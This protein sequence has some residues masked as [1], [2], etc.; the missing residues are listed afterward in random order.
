MAETET[1]YQIKKAANSVKV[2][3]IALFSFF[4]SLSVNE[5]YSSSGGWQNYSSLALVDLSF[6]YI[7]GVV[8]IELVKKRWVSCLLFMSVCASLIVT[9][10]MFLYQYY[11]LNFI[12]SIAQNSIYIYTSLSLAI[13]ILIL[14]VAVMP[15]GILRLIDDKFWPNSLADIYSCHISARTKTVKEIAS[16]WR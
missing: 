15:K 14:L 9:L 3:F 1:R 5:A 4:V 7:F 8:D 2:L 10:I 16:R 13:S 12:D 6:M 11:T